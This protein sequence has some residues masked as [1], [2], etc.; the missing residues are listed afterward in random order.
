MCGAVFLVM[1]NTQV[2]VTMDLLVRYI[3]IEIHF[4]Y[5]PMQYTQNFPFS[6]LQT[7]F[8]MPVK[9][10]VINVMIMWLSANAA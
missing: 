7:L 3:L 1:T 9:H 5:I 2:S 8:V 4:W 6:H 10:W